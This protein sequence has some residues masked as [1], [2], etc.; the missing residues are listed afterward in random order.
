MTNEDYVDE[1]PFVLG[2]EG[3]PV[4]SINNFLLMGGLLEGKM[5]IKVP[6]RFKSQAWDNLETPQKARFCK[7]TLQNMSG[8]NN[9]GTLQF[10]N[11][12]GCIIKSE[13]F[14]QMLDQISQLKITGTGLTNLTMNVLN[15]Y[16][17]T[18]ADDIIL[19]N[20]D[21]TDPAITI[22]DSDMEKDS[23]YLELVASGSV[24]V[25]N[26]T[27]TV[28]TKKMDGIGDFGINRSALSGGDLFPLHEADLDSDLQTKVNTGGSGTAINPYPVGSI[29][30]SVT[31][32]NPTTL[33]GGTWEQLKNKFLLAA[34]DATTGA[35][36]GDSGGEK[37]HTLSIAEMPIHKHDVDIGTKA[38]VNTATTSPGTSTDGAHRHDAKVTPAGGSG[39][40]SKI[41]SGAAP[42]S[43]LGDHIVSGGEHD[44]TVNAHAHQVPAHD[45][46]I[47]E[48]NKGSNAVH[49]NMPPYLA[50][51]MWKRI[52]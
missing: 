52:A 7:F 26:I 8:T 28:Q 27:L 43:T 16:P 2:A 37:D 31:N 49:N 33:F 51:Y 23:F 40:L 22:L 45:H 5:D 34:D 36:G 6:E 24:T 35:H 1:D 30:L 32:A 9:G 44:H 50:V 29:Y 10:A 3:L 38:A 14:M 12:Q 17:V 46:S 15:K 19:Q 42:Y 25:Q 48:S 47:L 39:S 21:L 41:Y 13:I 18:S 4:E 11:G 20:I